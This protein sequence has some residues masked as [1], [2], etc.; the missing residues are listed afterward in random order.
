MTEAKSL[1]PSRVARFLALRQRLGRATNDYR[2]GGHLQVVG[3]PTRPTD[4]YAVILS[5]IPPGP[6]EPSTPA[7]DRDL[8]GQ[9]R[10]GRASRPGRPPL[11]IW[12]CD[13]NQR[14]DGGRRP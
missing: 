11:I 10:P 8:A 14:S 9:V 3:T 2:A 13:D 7:V 12:C 6:T 4:D 5:V 1:S